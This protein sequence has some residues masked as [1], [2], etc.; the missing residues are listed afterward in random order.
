MAEKDDSG[1]F[2]RVVGLLNEANRII[3][4]IEKKDTGGSATGCANPSTSSANPSSSTSSAIN[5]STISS[6]GT[7]SPSTSNSSMQQ[8]S[9]ANGLNGG[10][11][12]R[13][14]ANFR[15]LFGKYS[16]S[17][18]KRP[19]SSATPASKRFKTSSSTYTVKETWTH[20]FLC[21]ADRFQNEQPTRAQKVDLQAAGLG[22]KRLVLN[23]NDNAEE[24]IVKVENAYPK[25][26]DQGGFELLRSGATN[27]Q[28]TEIIPPPSGYSVP[29]LKDM[30]GIGQAIIYIRPLQC[31]L[32]MD[33]VTPSFEV[34][35]YKIAFDVTILNFCSLLK[36]Y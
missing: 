28:L 32:N 9:C 24:F 27:K 1:S 5:S 30:A 20:N 6:G 10:G 35:N 4:S 34:C 17:G 16:N 26:K 36:Y 18:S 7:P 19:F 31:Q 11:S 22:R 12:S 2:S 23:K 33:A 21:L 14:M 25:L 15:S 13:A 3:E 8:V 29:F